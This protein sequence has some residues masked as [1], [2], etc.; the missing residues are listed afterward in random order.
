[1]KL[2]TPKLITFWVAVLFALVGLI[3]SLVEISGLS[4]YAFWIV[5][6]GFVILAAGNLFKDF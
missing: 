4:A 6:A 3:A 1:M 5:F 2:S